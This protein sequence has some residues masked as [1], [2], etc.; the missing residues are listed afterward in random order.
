MT[1]GRFH[2]A[3]SFSGCYGETTREFR[4]CHMRH[5]AGVVSPYSHGKR[6]GNVTKISI[7]YTV[8]FET[9]SMTFIRRTPTVRAAECR[10]K[11]ITE[12][13][14]CVQKQ[15]ENNPASRDTRL[16]EQQKQQTALIRFLLRHYMYLRIMAIIGEALDYH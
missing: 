1:P 12:L 4:H 3:G 15:P 7:L 5:L 16:K 10:I 11:T 6:H 2:D 14:C 13:A 9:F 8:I